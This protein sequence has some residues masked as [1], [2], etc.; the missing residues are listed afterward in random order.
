MRKKRALNPKPPW[1]DSW[2]PQ[3]WASAP[4]GDLYQE[5][6]AQRWAR[7]QPKRWQV[8]DLL[9]APTV[10]LS[11][12]LCFKYFT[13]WKFQQW[14]QFFWLSHDSQQPASPRGPQNLLNIRDQEVLSLWIVSKSFFLLRFWNK[15]PSILV[16]SFPLLGLSLADWKWG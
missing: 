9:P 12:D 11:S 6:V 14:L 13:C 2:G 7:S 1:A 5:Q 16:R 15:T 10:L 4:C 8:T 3:V